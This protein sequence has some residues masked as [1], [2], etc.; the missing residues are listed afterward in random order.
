MNAIQPS[1]PPLQTVDTRRVVR[2]R[3]PVKRSQQTTA[4]ALETTAKLAINILFSVAA[5]TALVQLLPYHKSVQVKLQEIDG[6]INVT[7]E[8]VDR[9]QKNFHDAFDPKQAKIIMQ[10]QSYRVDPAR[11]QIVLLDRDS[12]DR[13]ESDRSGSTP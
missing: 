6:E 9:L 11:R 2:H 4:I 3:R 12:K 8:R 1:R 7:Q 10:E 5:I 13:E